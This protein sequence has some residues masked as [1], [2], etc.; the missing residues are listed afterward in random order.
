MYGYDTISKRNI[1]KHQ[2][3]RYKILLMLFRTTQGKKYKSME[4][5][6]DTL[7]FFHPAK[8]CPANEIV[9]TVK[10]IYFLLDVL[11]AIN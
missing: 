5:C 3:G 6:K 1:F 4:I 10:T 11:V 8:L 9:I 7:R 2:T